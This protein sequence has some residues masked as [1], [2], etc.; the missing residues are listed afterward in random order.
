MWGSIEWILPA[1]KYLN[2]HYDNVKIV[3]L[4]LRERKNEIFKDNHELEGLTIEVS[5]KECVDLYHFLPGWVVYS[6]NF[7]GWLGRKMPG[8]LS[9]LSRKAHPHWFK[10][11]WHIFGTKRFRRWIDKIQPTLALMDSDGYGVFRELKRKEINI[12]FFLT[13]PSFAFSPIVWVDKDKRRLMYLHSPFDFFLVDTKWAADFFKGIAGER[14]VFEV[15]CP[16][17][18]TFWINYLKEKSDFGLNDSREH[19][20]KHI[21]VLLKNESSIIFK[22]IDFR[23]ALAEIIDSCLKIK[24]VHLTLKPHP[25]QNMILLK[26]IVSQYPGG[27]ITVSNEPSFV[28][29]NKSDLIIA[30]PNGVIIDA[31]ILRRPV[32]EY[33]DYIKL[34]R[35]LKDEFGQIPTGILGGMSYL[36]I[37]GSLTSVFRGL[38]LVLEANKQDELEPLIIKLINSDVSPEV[39]DI[40]NIFPDDGSKRAAETILSMAHY[41]KSKFYRLII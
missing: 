19:D 2:D 22:Y 20:F 37:N 29:I 32:V 8:V 25:R 40:R 38:G 13:S 14:P 35:I 4:I 21:L 6:L 12:G 39:K 41:D 23:E 5:S 36:D 3:F 24:N 17:F 28:L 31:L 15:G 11:N 33:F 26:E 30:F 1:C 34:N 7:M 10:L 18:D 16:K 27:R 9:R